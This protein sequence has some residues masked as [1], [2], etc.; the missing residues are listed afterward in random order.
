MD[1]HEIEFDR[2]HASIDRQAVI[3]FAQHRT[4]LAGGDTTRLVHLNTVGELAG[5]YAEALHADLDFVEKRYRRQ[6][7]EAA[8]FLHDTLLQGC[9]FESLVSLADE[10]VA[11]VVAA[12][13]PD[14]RLPAPK[15]MMMLGNA[16]GLAGGD[17][18]LVKLADLRHEAVLKAAAVES[19]PVGVRAWLSEASEV[20]SCLHQLR[21]TPLVTRIDAVKAAVG[22]L[23]D[24]TRSFRRKK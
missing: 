19:D 1:D 3:A 7:C 21:N 14:V 5:R 11:K 22:D 15:R 2:L 8:G 23:D 13:T 12:V 20:L 4:L 18:Q 16:I 6:V 10:A 9:D 24:R 17:A